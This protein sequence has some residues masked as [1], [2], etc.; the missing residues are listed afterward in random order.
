MN[1]LHPSKSRIRKLNLRQRKK[2]R[3]G[4][5]R[6]LVFSLRWTS[7]RPLEE[8]AQDGLLDNF[9][10]FIEARGLMYG[11][12]FAPDGGDGIVARFSRSS[13]SV[14]DRDAVLDWMRNAPLV[15]TADAGEFVDGWYGW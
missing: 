6:E 4:E 12:G 1:Q 13:T 5:F 8:I 14:D 11:G 3:M 2:L 7:S 9:I 15:A 10:A